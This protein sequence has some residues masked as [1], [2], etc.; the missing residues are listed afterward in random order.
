MQYPDAFP[1]SKIKIRVPHRRHDWISRDRLLEALHDDL[2]KQLL[3]IVAPAGYG[4]TTL[5]VDFAHNSE[6]PVC[7]LGLDILDKEPQRFLTYLVSSIA[8]RYPEFG[9]DVFAAMEGMKSFEQDGEHIL[10]ALSNEIEEKIGEHFVVILDDYHIVGDV[11]IIQQLLRRL[12]QLT[13]EHFHLILASRNLPDIPDISQLVIRNLVGGLSYEEMAFQPKEVQQLFLQANRTSLSLHD[14][15]ILVSETEGWIAAIQMSGGQPG[16]LSKVDPLRSTRELFDFFSKEVLARQPGN[17]QRFL[18]MTSFLDHFDVTLCEEVLTPLL[19]D[20]DDVT[21]APLFE[22]VRQENLFSILVDD[23]GRWMRYHHLFQHFL[24]SRLR[25]TEPALAWHIQQNLARAYEKREAWEEALQIY[26]E[27]DD[28]KNLSRLLSQ[29]G[30]VFI[31][32]GRVLTL[33]S[34]L[35]RLATEAIYSQPALLS[36]QGVVFVS[37]GEITKAIE[38]YTLAEEKVRV[39]Q[40][41]SDLALTLARR[42][43]AYRHL[44][45]FEQAL[46][47][48]EEALLLSKGNTSTLALKI[49][50]ADARRIKG[51]SFFGQGHLK[52]ALFELHEAL[53]ACRLLELTSKIPILETELGVVY[54]RL[55]DPDTAAR[56]YSSA[57]KV[58]EDA[59]NTGW[60]ARLLNNLGLLYHMTG[61]LDKAL[62][63]LEEAL[64]V[65]QKSGYIWLK[66]NEFISLGDLW[67]DIGDFEIAHEYYDQALTSATQLGDSLLIFY[68]TLGEARLKRLQGEFPQALVEYERT[69][70]N[71]VKLGLYEQA[72]LYLESGICLVQCGNTEQGIEA[73]EQAINLLDQNQNEME[74]ASARLWM[75][76]AIYEND[77]EAAL[78]LMKK[79]LPAP[80]SWS[81]A[82]PLMVNAGRI[83]DWTKRTSMFGIDDPLIVDFFQEAEKINENLSKLRIELQQ[84]ST[85]DTE[86][87]TLEFH[88]FGNVRVYKNGHELKVSDWQTR[89]AKELFFFFLQS[90]PMTKEKI[91]LV[92]WPDIT[93]AR[94][95]MRFKINVYRIRQALGQDVLL[96]DAGQYY[97][98]KKLSYKWDREQ[99]DN[100]IKMAEKASN[101]HEVL[102]R[103]LS[104]VQGPY[105]GDLHT[106]WADSD[107]FYYKE[108]IQHTMVELAEFFLRDGQVSRSLQI[109]RKI[110]ESDSLVEAGHRLLLQAYAALD[111]QVNLV[112]HYHEYEKILNCN[113]QD[114]L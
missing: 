54:R 4:K 93:P 32:G 12:L 58:W 2:D 65:A 39:S 49:A 83:V 26:A 30:S 78:S 40:D 27:L 97:F 71:Q 99:F 95:K 48:A 68:A 21:W 62:P 96:F 88:T 55:G 67:A 87:T 6:L 75:A 72:L 76:I 11:L 43:E 63:L 15:E 100:L 105:M 22:I 60:K 86:Q 108:I 24:R 101:R 80:K 69:K 70:I 81:M 79:L 46:T 7:W 45:Q 104:I 42:A 109:A 114:K 52:K 20:E 98:N 110:I 8:E 90:P 3:L 94:L 53:H 38:F 1:I 19:T 102:V 91:G 92:F 112:R 56:Y 82:T 64:E 73:L 13:G 23:D 66:T 25:Y 17:I 34:W 47:D 111:D 59:S 44:G 9:K 31:R 37:K 77:P 14:A 5:L 36:L 57:L 107:R 89:E 85:K 84:V 10:I 61:E 50:Y 35:D 18:L 74:Q 41:Q 51:L 29:T 28:N 16:N 106:D 33:A 113:S 103:A